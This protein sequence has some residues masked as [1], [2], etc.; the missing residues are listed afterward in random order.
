MD[1][2][3]LDVSAD[4]SEMTYIASVHVGHVLRMQVK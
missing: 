2:P 3:V 1:T 4:A